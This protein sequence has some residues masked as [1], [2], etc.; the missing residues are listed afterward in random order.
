M[1]QVLTEIFDYI[2]ITNARDPGLDP[3]TS[4]APG[5]GN[6]PYAAYNTYN[7]GN[8]DTAGGYGQIVP[9]QYSTWGT[10]G[11][12]RGNLT[13]VNVGIIFIG[14]GQGL[15]LPNTTDYTKPYTAVNMIMANQESNQFAP[16]QG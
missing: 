9:T 7:P 11:F 16:L 1:R 3:G 12:G 10:Y 15:T 14:L 6:S 13:L 2:R 4:A 8:D 5:N